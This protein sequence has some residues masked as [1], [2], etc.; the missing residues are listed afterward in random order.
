MN[1]QQ[2]IFDDNGNWYMADRCESAWLMPENYQAPNG[3]WASPEFSGQMVNDGDNRG[4]Q[5]VECSESHYD[6]AVDS[7]SGS[8]GY[9]T[10][11]GRYWV[12]AD[13]KF[14]AAAATSMTEEDAQ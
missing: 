10:A 6:T 5:V 1:V 8:D 13:G 14:A 11:D 12:D 9:R 2:I 4:I 3:R 7:T